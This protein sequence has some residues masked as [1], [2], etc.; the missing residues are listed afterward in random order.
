[1]L[2]FSQFSSSRSFHGVLLLG[3]LYFGKCKWQRGWR[4]GAW[5]DG[6]WPFG[7]WLVGVKIWDQ[8][9]EIVANSWHISTINLHK[10]TVQTWDFIE[11][12]IWR[13]WS[14]K[15]KHRKT[16]HFPP[17]IVACG[18]RAAQKPVWSLESPPAY[19]SPGARIIL[20]LRIYY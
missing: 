16:K 11:I 1:M 15:G 7:K 12:T 8:N 19:Q 14:W 20:L 10:S 17:E 2:L 18:Q 9:T 4:A 5:L 3:T 13:T 6:Q